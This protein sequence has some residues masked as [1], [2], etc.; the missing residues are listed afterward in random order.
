[1]KMRIRVEDR[2]YDVEVDFLEGAAN[3]NE[4][5]SGLEAQ[6]PA[7]VFRRR[8]PQKLPEDNVCRSPIAGRVTAVMGAAGGNVRRNQPVVLIEAMKM[9][10]PIG[11]A[12]DGTL[13]IVH[14]AAGETVGAGQVLFEIS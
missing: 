7:T 10:I 4:S 2:A 14:V 3:A 9:Q 13:K 5:R 6:L 1:M 11:P 8:P 12:V